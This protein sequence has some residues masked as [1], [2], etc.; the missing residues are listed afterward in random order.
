[1]SWR[2]RLYEQALRCRAQL[3]FDDAAR[4]FDSSAVLPDPARAAIEDELRELDEVLTAVPVAEVDA[5]AD[6]LRDDARCGGMYDRPVDE[7]AHGLDCAADQLE[8]LIR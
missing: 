8:E 4:V 6:H 7:Y 3:D 2:H 1:V 5:L